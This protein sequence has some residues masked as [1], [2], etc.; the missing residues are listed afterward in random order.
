MYWIVAAYYAWMEIFKA[1]KKADKEIREAALRFAP[2][3]SA[4]SKICP[5]NEGQ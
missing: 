2:R 4:H 1:A 5:Q 3:F